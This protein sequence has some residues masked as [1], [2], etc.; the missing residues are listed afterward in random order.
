M[1][2]DRW[3]NTTRQKYFAK[4]SRKENNFKSLCIEIQRLLENEMY[5]Y[6]G[7]N[8]SHQNSNKMLRKIW[9]P[10]QEDI[11]YIHYKDSYTGNITHNTE[12]AAV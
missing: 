9:K 10:Y 6:T 5:D 2:T 8:W 1:H 4:E 7:N 12:S 3:G 11:R